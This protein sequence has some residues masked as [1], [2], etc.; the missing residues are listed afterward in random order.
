MTR[1]EKIAVGILRPI[2]TSL[3]VIVGGYTILWGLWFICPFWSV[4]SS[5]ALYSVMAEIAPG[6]VWGCI[7]VLAGAI[8]TRGALKPSSANLQWGALAGFF[9][10]FAISMMYFLGDFTNT[11]GITAL[12]FALYF[13]VIW[14]N[15][16]VNRCHYDS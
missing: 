2:N 4:L 8:I 9:H 3:T 11:G 15:V 12:V 14:V 16:K 7:A 10:W 5:A 1:T 13:C 6:Y